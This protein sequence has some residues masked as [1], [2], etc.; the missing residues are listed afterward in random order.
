MGDIL[1][2]EV[3]FGNLFN[4]L[5]IMDYKE[6]YEKALC[7]AKKWLN[8]PNVDKIP[9]FANRV[10]E[11]I[12]PELKKSEDERIRKRLY[13]LVH[14]MGSDILQSYLLTK[15]DT[16]AWLEK[17]GEPKPQGKTALE[18]IKEEKVD[19]QNCVKPVDEVGQKLKVGDIVQYITNSTDRRK[20]EE[21]DTLC[22]M[23]HTDSSP[24]MFEI[25]DEWKVVENTEMIEALRT[26][27]EKGRA[28]AY[29]QIDDV[30]GRDAVKAECILP[31]GTE[32][33]E[34]EYGEII[35]NQI[36]IKELKPLK[37]E[38]KKEEL[39]R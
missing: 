25:E 24:I 14:D 22:N 26:E 11:E 16:L 20:I 23:Y 31:K 37:D 38:S 7:N 35:S 13:T 30:N 5:F 12:F 27:Y 18:A 17:Q 8:A 9:T 3:L 39:Q 32:Y 15:T 19:N 29:G 10:I 33:Y 21:I 6:K 1:M 34:N 28:D 4:L 2:Q 36:V